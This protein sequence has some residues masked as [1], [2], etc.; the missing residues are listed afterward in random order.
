[1]EL[2]PPR[3]PRSYEYETDRQTDN[4]KRGRNV[5]HESN[6]NIRNIVHIDRVNTKRC[7]GMEY[8]DQQWLGKRQIFSAQPV[9]IN[10]N[11]P[12]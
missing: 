4:D 11:R 9:V 6:D 5:L 7:N 1:M 8:V 2:Q 10:S 3:P 12:T